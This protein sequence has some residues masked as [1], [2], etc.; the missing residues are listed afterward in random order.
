VP[1]VD[2]GALLELKMVQYPSK[3]RLLQQSA[4]MR[5]EP[6]GCSGL[7]AGP[8]QIAP[9]I[10]EKRL[11]NLARF[12]SSFI[13]ENIQ[14]VTQRAPKMRP[15]IDQRKGK[16]KNVSLTR[17]KDA[18]GMVFGDFWVPFWRVLV[19]FGSTFGAFGHSLLKALMLQRAWSQ[20]LNSW[21]QPL[22]RSFFLKRA[23]P[24]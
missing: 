24:E 23:S 13:S 8:P 9:K 5:L 10:F 11:G 16:L 19:P 3:S 2:F 7:R 12:R 1:G 20:C 18:F 15:Q 22:S 21:G 14:K 4:D 6:A 17:S